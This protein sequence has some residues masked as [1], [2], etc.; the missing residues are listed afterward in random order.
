[1]RSNTTKITCDLK[2]CS[3]IFYLPDPPEK[4]TEGIEQVL[5]VMS[6][7]GKRLHFCEWRHL[8]QFGVEFL[9]ATPP[10]G[11]A[12]KAMEEIETV[13]QTPDDFILRG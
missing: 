11:N 3:K 1:M 10:T 8:L 2:K 7:E 9:K 12:H 13:S 5:E 4:P 6:A